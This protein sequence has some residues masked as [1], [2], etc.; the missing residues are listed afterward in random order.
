MADD[1]NG[2]GRPRC[3]R[4][5]AYE[6]EHTGD[7]YL[8][9]AD[10]LTGPAAERPA[11]PGPVSSHVLVVTGRKPDPDNPGRYFDD[12]LQAHVECLDPE[13]TRCQLW[14]QCLQCRNASFTT[15]LW[16]KEDAVIHAVS[17]RVREGVLVTD[18]GQCISSWDDCHD[19]AKAAAEEVAG[20]GRWY[21]EM[22]WGEGL[23]V[24]VGQTPT[25][26]PEPAG[27]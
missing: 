3:D 10:T 17:H 24:I 14:I 22:T 12:D 26:A 6:D 27:A 9:P 23:Q 19:A 1:C 25:P 21:V 16:H 15:V 5:R 20:N 18:T 13:R 4:C 11:F 2:D 8:V 7:T